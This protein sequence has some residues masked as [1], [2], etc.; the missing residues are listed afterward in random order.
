CKIYNILEIGAPVLYV[1]PTTSHIV[2]VLSG[3]EDQK[4]ICSCRHGEVETVADYI[5]SG[6]EKVRGRRS[7]SAVKV[8]ASFSKDALLPRLVGLIDCVPEG[9]LSASVVSGTK[10]QL[11]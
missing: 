5:V 8:A 6:A 1:G 3:L 10:P 11:T 9:Q 4:L 7:P 2:D